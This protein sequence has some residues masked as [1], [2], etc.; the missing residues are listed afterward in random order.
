MPSRWAKA[1]DPARNRAPSGGPSR[2]NARRVAEPSETP[3]DSATLRAAAR[4]LSRRVKWL[5][6][7]AGGGLGGG[8]GG[9]AHPWKAPREWRGSTSWSVQPSELAPHCPDRYP[10]RS[11]RL[12]R[13][14]RRAPVSA[15][16]CGPRAGG[17][18]GAAP[19]LRVRRRRQRGRP[20]ARR[21]AAGGG[22]AVGR[23]PCIAQPLHRE[24]GGEA[25]G[26]ERGRRRE[27]VVKRVL[28]GDKHAVH[29]RVACGVRAGSR[30]HLQRSERPGPPVPLA[31]VLPHLPRPPP[32]RA[33]RRRRRRRRRRGRRGAARAM[34]GGA[35]AR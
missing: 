5:S 15:R 8:Q 33:Q 26:G 35:R 14:P 31:H 11:T 9:G 1:G 13:R 22:V 12:P 17:R 28:G 3:S 34:R 32:S 7:R 29:A 27:R 4:A 21:A 6:T 18:V 23:E 2:S 20:R 24:A 16:P 25:C 30:P 10:T 19:C